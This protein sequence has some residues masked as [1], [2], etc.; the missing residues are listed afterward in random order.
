MKQKKKDFILCYGNYNLYQYELDEEI[1]EGNTSQTFKLI[2][3]YAQDGM[4]NL[5]IIS[6][7]KMYPNRKLSKPEK[8]N[9]YLWLDDNHLLY[10]ISQDGIYL[11]NCI[12]ATTNKLISGN[13]KF[14]L[15]EVENDIVK[16]DDTQVKITL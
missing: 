10:S 2:C 9:S 6:L 11:Y 16:Y 15:K 4:S 3:T 5:R 13:E 12:Q 7:N 8:I 14:K 1:E